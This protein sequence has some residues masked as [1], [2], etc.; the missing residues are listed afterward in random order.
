MIEITPFFTIT[1]IKLLN[2]QIIIKKKVY[3]KESLKF[4]VKTK[5]KTRKQ[6]NLVDAYTNKR[7]RPPHMRV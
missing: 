1:L 6:A 3:Q 2:N 5:P 7:A 4:T